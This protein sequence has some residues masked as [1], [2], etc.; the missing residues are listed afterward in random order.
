MPP[1]KNPRQCAQCDTEFHPKT[2]NQRFCGYRCNQ[3][4]YRNRSIR[5]HRAAKKATQTVP[6]VTLDTMKLAFESSR[7]HLPL[8]TE[9]RKALINDLRVAKEAGELPPAPALRLLLR[10]EPSTGQLFWRERPVEMF[11]DAVAAR[12]WNGAFARKEAFKSNKRGYATGCILYRTLFAH[13]VIWALVYSAWPSN[14]IDH[15]S[16]EKDDNRIE[17]LRVVSGSENMRNKK[18]YS[19]NL[20]GRVGVVFHRRDK[21]WHARIRVNNKKI[22]LGAYRT[23]EEACA[24]RSI[25]EDRLGFHRNHGRSDAIAH[26]SSEVSPAR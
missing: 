21:R 22:H 18:R 25:A 23:F 1:Q 4:F 14:D 12:R 26:R 3:K 8:S 13:R 10:Y 7:E 17:N 15:I 5:E 2:S 24:A 11:P 16:G 9:V 6:E 20:S 19:N